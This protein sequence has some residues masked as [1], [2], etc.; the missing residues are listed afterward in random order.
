MFRSEE[1]ITWTNITPTIFQRFMDA[2]HQYYNSQDQNEIWYFGSTN[3]ST[4]NG[5]SVF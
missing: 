3:A 1:G 2:M 4:A 5:H